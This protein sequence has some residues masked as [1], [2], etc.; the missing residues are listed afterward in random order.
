MA[1]RLVKQLAYRFRHALEAHGSVVPRE[2]P[3]GP[4]A[5]RFVELLH[6]R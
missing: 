4:L 2:R 5:A 3:P 6:R 1:R